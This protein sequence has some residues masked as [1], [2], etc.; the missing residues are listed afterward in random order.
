MYS[1]LNYTLCP[2]ISTLA[3]NNM[4]KNIFSSMHIIYRH[5]LT[6]MKLSTKVLHT[7]HMNTSYLKKDKFIACKIEETIPY[8]SKR[9]KVK[10]A[11]TLAYK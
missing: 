5:V 8:I 1:I 4:Y 3:N 11:S 9:S 6:T 7:K 10:A 2:K